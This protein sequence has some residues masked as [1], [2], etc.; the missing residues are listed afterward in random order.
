[1][2][3]KHLYNC[4]N[5]VQRQYFFETKEY[6]NSIDIY[7]Q[8]KNLEA[9]RYL[10]TKVS[11]QIVRRVSEAWK[12]WLAALKDWSKHPE[13]YRGLPKMPGYKHKERGRNVVIYPID[14]I[15]KPALAKGI[16][17]L[18]QTNIEFPTN[19]KSVAQVRIVP[20][21]DHYVIEVVY[22]ND[23]PLSNGKYVAGVDLGLKNLMA[24]TSN[25]PGVR[26][27]SD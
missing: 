11:K 3:S 18:S 14:A 1:M 6:Y 7:H 8:T 26:P 15:S 24:I 5:Y 27:M 16:V 13:K 23:A 25:H 9:Y 17:K 2:Q 12:G 4:A 10:P 20:K 19:A 21:L 22:I